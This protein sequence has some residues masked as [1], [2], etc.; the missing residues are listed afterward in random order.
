MYMRK[1]Y[2]ESRIETCPFCGRQAIIK[3]VQGI[4]VCTDHRDK[5]LPEMKCT[6]GEHLLIQNGKFGVFFNCFKC[7]NINF[8]K[9]LEINP[10]IMKAEK[11]KEKVERPEIAK[12]QESRIQT[13]RSDDSRFF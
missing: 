2:G 7:G 3:N 11:I 10:D 8:R 12:K 4:P 1:R 5:L 13:V 9:I 6:C